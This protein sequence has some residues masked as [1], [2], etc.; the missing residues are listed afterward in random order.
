MSL[1]H[2]IYA[3]SA[4][5]SFSEAV[6][7]VLLERARAKNIVR[8]ITGMLLFIEGSFFQ[9][10]EGE[11]HVVDEIYS[12][13]ERDPRHARVTRI[14]REPI[15]HRTFDQWSMGFA[16]VARLDARDLLGANDFFGSAACLEGLDPGRAK[17]L[18]TA[19]R[20]GRWRTETTGV[21]RAHVRVG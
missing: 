2:C 20:A 4:V 5:P 10:L 11:T 8:G 3:S 14:I 17:K 9:V 21:H 7:P 15:A 18:L 12:A 13:I 16:A 6:I 19:F 1:I